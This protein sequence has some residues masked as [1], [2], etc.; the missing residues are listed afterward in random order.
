[1]CV[2][3]GY[4]C[5]IIMHTMLLICYSWRHINRGALVASDADHSEHPPC[6]TS[7]TGSSSSS[8]PSRLSAT[9]RTQWL[10][11]PSQLLKRGSRR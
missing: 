6:G 8:L 11:S 5:G 7:C 10:R 3:G 9:S 4:A 1:M 2:C